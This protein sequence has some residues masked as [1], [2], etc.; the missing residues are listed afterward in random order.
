MR[1]VTLLAL[2]VILLTSCG[3]VTGPADTSADLSGRTF[4]STAVTSDGDARELVE[5]S[6]ISLAF[7]DGRLTAQAGCNTMSGDYRIE[8]EVLVVDALG[9]TR[10][11]CPGDLA[12]QDIW[13]SDLLTSRPTL[14]LHDDELVLTTPTETVTLLDRVVADPDRPLVGTVW[15]VDSLISGDTV[16]STPGT[17]EASLTF[18]GDGTVQVRGGC[19]TGSASYTVGEGTLTV[20]PVA[21]TRMACGD[22]RGELEAA[23]LRVLE[24]GELQMEIEADRLTLSAD[25]AGLGLHAG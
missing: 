18:G 11:G 6:R 25:G 20:G 5:G 22:E 15:R 14:A 23:V 19:N 12:E 9:M 16:S 1:A 8:D 3:S 21:M 2:A 13:L 10:M 4:L 7:A 24:A 17:A